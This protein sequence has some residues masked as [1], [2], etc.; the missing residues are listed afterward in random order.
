[1]KWVKVVKRYALP[2]IRPIHL[3]HGRNGHEM[4]SVETP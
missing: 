1:M 4:Y 2:V 3:P